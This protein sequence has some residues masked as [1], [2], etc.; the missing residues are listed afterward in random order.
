MTIQEQTV[1]LK[2]ARQSSLFTTGFALFSMFF[3]AGNLIFPLIIGKSVGGNCWYAI[4]GLGITAVIVPFLGLAGMIFFQADCRRFFNRIGTAPGFLLLLLLQLILGPF[5]VIPRL[6]TLMHAIIKPYFLDLSLPV[7][8]VVAACIVFICSFRRQNLI[9]LLGIIL[10]P[11]LLIS[12]ACLFVSGMA[13]NSHVAPSVQVPASNSFFQGLLG[14]YNT[15]DL[16]AAFLFATVVLPHFQKEVD[17]DPSADKKK[18]L[19][20]KMFFSSA[21]AAALLLFT[22]IGLCFISSYHGE[23]AGLASPSEDLLGAIAIKLLGPIGGFIS[24]IAIVTA[25]LTTAITLALIFADYLRKDLCKDKISPLAS[26]V[27]T[28]LVTTCFSNLGFTGI[29]AFLG[30]ILQICYPG[31][32]V[33]TILN[34]VYYLTG[35]KAI[36][37]PVFLTFAASAVLYLLQN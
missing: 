8:S 22:Y 36:K 11:I 29:S 37:V 28:L 4:L 33:L 25:C 14:G 5:G 12:L 19:S 21:I 10:T 7:F 15:M 6:F 35:F 18:A 17:A 26:L 1:P 24:A 30:P 3:G 32:I 20:K 2:A 23:A 31:L 27:I 9:G 34:I 13:Y 16:I